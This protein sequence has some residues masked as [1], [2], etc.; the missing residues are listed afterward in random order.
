[1]AGRNGKRGRTRVADPLL[2]RDP[3][4]GVLLA[5]VGCL[6]L[7][8]LIAV[9]VDRQ[10]LTL[11][12]ALAAGGL[13]GVAYS[14]MVL[15]LYRWGRLSIRDDGG[16]VYDPVRFGILVAAIVLPVLLLLAAFAVG[17][18]MLAPDRPALLAQA[19]TGAL[20]GGFFLGAGLYYLRPPDR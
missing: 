10:D 8:G 12:N 5:G 7:G 4:V 13:V 6:G 11:G 16:I 15:A 3:L 9:A 1:M 14:R 17:R 19:A 2:A 18:L 20:L